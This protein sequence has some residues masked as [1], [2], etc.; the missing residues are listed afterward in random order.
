MRAKGEM[1]IGV[2]V[3]GETWIGEETQRREKE[4]KITVAETDAKTKEKEIE[5]WF[6]GK[7][8]EMKRGLSGWS[9][10]WLMHFIKKHIEYS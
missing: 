9:N 7:K 6:R 10:T 1:F 5:L 4:T 3:S 8:R 2:T